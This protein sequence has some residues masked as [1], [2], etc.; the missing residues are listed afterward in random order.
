[1]YPSKRGKL[2]NAFPGDPHW[3]DVSIFSTKIVPT[4]N[5]Y[6]SCNDR[7]FKWSK[8]TWSFQ[9]LIG[10]TYCAWQR[11][12]AHPTYNGASWCVPARL[13]LHNNFT[14]DDIILNWISCTRSVRRAGRSGFGKIGLFLLLPLYKFTSKCKPSVKRASRGCHSTFDPTQRR[15]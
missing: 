3:R 12:I 13:H 6:F 5:S 4:D 9:L 2:N 7:S 1:M 8:Y 14:N 10:S 15:I 11:R